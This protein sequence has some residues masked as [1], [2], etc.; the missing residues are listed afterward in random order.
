MTETPANTD[1]ATETVALSATV[2]HQPSPSKF[3]VPEH[4]Q[5]SFWALIA[6][7]FQGAFSDNALKNLVIFIILAMDLPSERKEQ[8]VPLV[9]ALF[10]APFILFSMAGGYFADRY[11]K[12]KVTIATKVMEIAVMLVALTGLASGILAIKLTAIFLLSTQAALF[13]PSKYGLLPELLPEKELSWGNGVLELGTFLAIILGTVAG[14]FLATHFA[15]RQEWSGMILIAISVAGLSTSYGIS[16]VPAAD[17]ERKFKINFI[18]ELWLQMAAIRKDR[19]LYL[20]VIGNAYFFLLTALLLSDVPIY[21]QVILRVSETSGSYLMAA[22]AIGIG[23]GSLVA[24]YISGHK[25]EYGLIPLGSIGMTIFG[26][27]LF[28]HGLPYWGVGVLLAVLGLFAGLFIVPINAMI[29]HRPDPAKKGGVIAAA[30]LL[31]FI[32]VFIAAGIYYLLTAKVAVGDKLLFHLRLTPDEVFLACGLISLGATLYVVKALPQAFMRLLFLMATHTIYRIRVEGRENIPARGGALFV[33]NHLSFVD[34]LLL[35]A[36][37]QRNVRFIMFQDI[38]DSPLIKPFAELMKA[39]PISSNL[40]PREMIRSL[41]TATDAIKEGRVVC[42][43]AEGEITRIGRMLPFRRGMERIMKGVDAPI[44]PVHLDG[45]WGSMFSFQ[46]GKF[47]WKKPRS[48]PFPVTVSFG[49]AMPATA[50]AND[51]RMAVQELETA[52]FQHQK[53]HM[54]T[55]HRTFVRAA[56][57]H[58]RRFAMGDGKVPY[59]SYGSVLVKS[60]YLARRLKEVWKDQEMVGI[61]IPP[62][63]GGALVNYAASLCGKVPVNFNY[64]ASNE[65]TASCAQQCNVTTTITSKAFLEKVPNLQPPGKVILLEDLAAN[66]S[67]LEKLTAFAMAWLLPFEALEKALG[68]AKLS[69]LDDLAT[70]IFSSGST[71]DPKGVMLSH[72]NIASNIDQMGRT[73]ALGKDDRIMGI[74][75]FFH[76]FGFTATLWL[77]MSLGMGVVFHPN[78]LDAVTIGA[79]VRTYAVTFLVAT[80]TFLQAYTRRCAPEDFG[81][82]Q[83]VIVGAEKLNERVAQAFEDTFGL[84][85]LEGYGCTECS[86][87][88]AVNTRDFRGAGFLQ[89]GHKRG[90][91][92]HPLPGVSVRIVDL[93][94]GVPVPIGQT[95]LMHVR[96]PNMMVGYLGRPDKTAEVL[97]D[98]WYN[99][100]DIAMMDEDGFLT[101]T[102]RLSRFSKIG[103]EM[104]PH[105]KVEETLQDCAQTPEQTFAVTGVPDGKK[106]ERLVVLHL[107][108]E[109]KLKEV[110]NKFDG[111]ELPPLWKPKPNQFFHIDSIP[112][113][114]TGKMDLR[115]IKELAVQASGAEG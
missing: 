81:S 108:P 110:L 100:G 109:D 111:V 12:R 95:G 1:A 16:R 9:L 54:E 17:P 25:I 64:T 101:I 10:S 59:V 34:A 65:I 87:V 112:Y 80:P 63:V 55:L 5:R 23:M 86:P 99:T 52:A 38:Y 51:V 115:R 32:G 44:I 82:L 96:G 28:I 2:P 71:G 79:L 56:R 89:V 47:F 24:G 15:G 14:G 98:G 76:S 92:G 70:V 3:P 66:P 62:S 102:D 42:I 53:K 113:L 114:G 90:K 74:L 58:P 77:P 60:I 57:K 91:I 72:Y 50:T 85:P 75:P 20:A 68:C 6:T 93:E 35:A 19:A 11:S 97:K 27:A 30:N 22:A 29:Q 67:L 21:S 69:K 106:G 26:T 13:G 45:V 107:L 48:V 94:T 8:M 33:S 37:T 43:F 41:R 83:F 84:R 31:S 39:I 49:K 88:V 46:R 78:P 4:W 61:L 103:G 36:S 73:F 7:Q 18:A 40:R 104:V 105:I